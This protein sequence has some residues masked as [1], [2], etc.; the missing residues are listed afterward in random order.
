MY[1]GK[2]DRKKGRDY[3]QTDLYREKKWKEGEIVRMRKKGEG[4]IPD[5]SVQEEK[6]KREKECVLRH[7]KKYM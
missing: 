3:S 2:T 4:L 6:W 5:R 1:R 7:E